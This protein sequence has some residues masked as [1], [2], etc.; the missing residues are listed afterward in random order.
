MGEKMRLPEMTRS[1]INKLTGDILFRNS[2]YLMLSTVILTGLGFFFWTISA[3]LYSA[4]DVGLAT[5]VISAMNL[6]ANIGSLGLGIALV[7][8]LPNSKD[9]SS[10]INSCMAVT[11]LVFVAGLAVFSPKLIFIRKSLYLG[12]VFIAF[13][14]FQAESNL[15]DRVFVALRDTKYTLIKNTVFSIGKLILPFLLVAYGSYGIFSSWGLSLL[16]SFV[17]CLVI[18]ARHFS[19][20]PEAVIYDGILRK[21]IGFSFSNYISNMLNLLPGLVLPLLVT[22]YLS[23]T[24]TAYYYVAMMIASLVFMIPIA[25]SSSMFAEGSKRRKELRRITYKSSWLI[26]VLMIPAMAL[27]IIAGPM[28]LGLFG[29]LYRTEGTMLLIILV[30][31]AVPQAFKAIYMSVLNVEHRMAELITANAIISIAVIGLTLAFTGHGL[32]GLG[33]AWLLGQSAIFPVM[34]ISRLISKFRH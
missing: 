5:T 26:T 12:M 1:F 30:L 28:L 16:V 19:I 29:T 3:K 11:A 13:V 17:Y 31:S 2:I 15:L 27:M 24:D 34:L 6:I 20:R 9:Q 7:R 21:I 4:H 8:F 18:L 23:P 14:V 32:T 10:L 22:Q 25:V 33:F